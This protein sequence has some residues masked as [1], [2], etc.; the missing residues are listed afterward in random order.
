[1]PQRVRKPLSGVILRSK[2]G[3]KTITIHP[4]IDIPDQGMSRKTFS[5]ILLCAKHL[6]KHRYSPLRVNSYSHLLS[7]NGHFVVYPFLS[8]PG[9]GWHIFAEQ[10]MFPPRFA[11]QSRPLIGA[12]ATAAVFA[13]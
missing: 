12:I 10:L 5:D 13:K 6:V 4:K 9:R 3:V 11:P 7:K 8:S 1:M 2:I